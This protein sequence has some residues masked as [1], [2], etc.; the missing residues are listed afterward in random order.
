MLT[1]TPSSGVSPSRIRRAVLPGCAAS[2]LIGAFALSSGWSELAGLCLVA[3]ACLVPVAFFVG[4]LNVTREISEEE[5]AV[6]RHFDFY[7]PSW[8]F[9][10]AIYRYLTAYSL[11]G[12]TNR[13][14]IERGG[15]YV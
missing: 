4:H 1:T 8:D 9:W 13:R 10:R 6:W 11:Q 5:K 2:F 12:A 15:R 3:G 7:P 14:R